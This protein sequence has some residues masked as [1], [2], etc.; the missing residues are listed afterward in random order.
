[1][2]RASAPSPPPSPQRL[3]SGPNKF[4][5]A[6]PITSS[7]FLSGTPLR[8]QSEPRVTRAELPAAHTA[9]GREGRLQGEAETDRQTHT[10]THICTLCRSK[11]LQFDT[12][13][14]LNRKSSEVPY[15]SKLSNTHT[16]KNKSSLLA[17]TIHFSLLFP[18]MYRGRSY[19]IRLTGSQ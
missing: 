12:S 1:M 2:R 6:R 18:R 14:R 8:K 9:R 10:H 3:C 11:H 19:Q 4:S 16:P 15:R 7:Y 5:V 13:C 17:Q